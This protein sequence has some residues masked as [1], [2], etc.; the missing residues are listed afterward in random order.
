[1]SPL[2]CTKCPITNSLYSQPNVLISDST[3]P[4]A[5]LADLGLTRVTTIQELMF[6][7]EKGTAA[8]TAP[9]LLL[10]A[11]FGLEKGIPSKEADIYALGMT[12]YRVLTGERPFF[13]KMETEIVHAVMSGE[14]P[15]KP[16]NAEAIGMTDAVWD[17]LKESWREDK[18]ERPGI[19]KI[20]GTFCDITGER[21]TADSRVG[22]AEPQLD[23]DGELNL[24]PV[25]LVTWTCLEH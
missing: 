22:I 10:P 12:V 17:L 13:P 23:G 2:T 9:E 4:R 14:R 16:G 8:F 20:L 15:P 3:P 24:R 25:S 1:M 21:K 6:G 5:I 11:K 19:S 18:I 7:G